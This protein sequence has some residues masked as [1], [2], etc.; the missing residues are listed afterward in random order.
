MQKGCH[1]SPHIARVL[2][3]LPG[4]SQSGS[5]QMPLMRVL[6]HNSMMRDVPVNNGGEGK[7]DST[8][9]ACQASYYL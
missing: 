8:L 4:L 5:M 2:P 9:A 6:K 1:A 7:K 3:C